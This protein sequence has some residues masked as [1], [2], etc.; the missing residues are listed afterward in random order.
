MRV[1]ARSE[2]TDETRACTLCGPGSI[3][4]LRHIHLECAPSIMEA[5]TN[6]FRRAAD[7]IQEALAGQLPEAEFLLAYQSLIYSHPHGETIL[8]G[9]LTP[10]IM[11]KVDLIPLHQRLS[12][13]RAYRAIVNHSRKFYVPLCLDIHQ[14]R[15]ALLTPPGVPAGNVRRRP[16]GIASHLLPSQIREMTSRDTDYIGLC[17]PADE[18]RASSTPHRQRR[19]RSLGRRRPRGQK[20]LR[21]FWPN[22]TPSDPTCSPHSSP[23]DPS[24]PLELPHPDNLP[25]APPLRIGVTPPLVGSPSDDSS[26]LGPQR[27][28]ATCV[29]SRIPRPL[30]Q[31]NSDYRSLTPLPSTDLI[32]T[33]EAHSVTRVPRAANCPSL[34]TALPLSDRRPPEGR[35]TRKRSAPAT[36]DACSTDCVTH[37]TR[38]DPPAA[39]ETSLGGDASSRRPRGHRHA[40]LLIHHLPLIPHFN[41]TRSCCM[42]FRRT[43]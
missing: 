3:E 38:L 25:I 6:G 10:S 23:P 34:S 19:S 31:S 12:G 36:L 5:M 42:A 37:L 24:P 35:V 8:T 15:S 17:P 40:P 2:D 14:A 41:S 4:T 13:G 43:R 9:L 27:Q 1:R 29:G 32:S 11:H 28:Q 21:A 7:S 20:S 33:D 26:H 39:G 16:Q 18:T 30:P 22:P